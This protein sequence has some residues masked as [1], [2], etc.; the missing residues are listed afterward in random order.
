ME[1]LNE[2]RCNSPSFWCG[3]ENHGAAR[4]NGTHH[5]VVGNCRWEIPRAGHKH[6]SVGCPGETARDE[7]LVRNGGVSGIGCEV[8]GFGHFRVTFTNR[9]A[10][11]LRHDYQGFTTAL[12]HDLSNLSQNNATG[13]KRH[14]LPLLLRNV[15]TFHGCV[16]FRD[17]L[18]QLWLRDCCR[19]E[20][21]FDPFAI[22]RKSEVSVNTGN[23][24][25]INRVADYLLAPVLGPASDT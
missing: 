8:N 9:F 24:G 25:A 7:L 15:C 17:G 16:H 10:H 19:C 13:R 5:T 22:G 11:G 4:C 1:L 18:Y 6:E 3:L 23:E 21:G 2:Y 12:L 20:S 14:A